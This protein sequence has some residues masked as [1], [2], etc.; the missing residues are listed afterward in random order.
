MWERNLDIV[1]T[2]VDYLFV[3]DEECPLEPL[4][5]STKEKVNNYNKW[6]KS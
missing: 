6:K 4:D 2:V 1:M 3:L 5:E